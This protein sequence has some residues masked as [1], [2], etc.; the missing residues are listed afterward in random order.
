[1]DRPIPI[2]DAKHQMLNYRISSGELGI[3]KLTPRSRKI[4]IS[5]CTSIRKVLFGIIN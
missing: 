2:F 4:G 3:R 1:M 5:R